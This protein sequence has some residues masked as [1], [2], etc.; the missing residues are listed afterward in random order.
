MSS[1]LETFRSRVKDRNL[2]EDFQTRL[3]RSINRVLRA[4]ACANATHE[5]RKEFVDY[6]FTFLDAKLEFL[7]K[8]GEISMLH[9]E[10]VD[11][12]DARRRAIREIMQG[13]EKSV[14]SIVDALA[15][16]S[17]PVMATTKTVQRDLKAM[18]AEWVSKTKTWKLP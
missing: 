3:A 7:C 11:P 12:M 17:A 18:K 8:L 16:R 15:K 5:V 4:I 9:G 13:Q 2:W 6:A 14:T 1:A 10:M